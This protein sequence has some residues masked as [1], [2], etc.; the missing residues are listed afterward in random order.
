MTTQPPTNRPTTPL[1]PN[2]QVASRD[3]PFYFHTSDE[4]LLSVF[5][6]VYAAGVTPK[7][8]VLPEM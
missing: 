4:K 3:R 6:A 2:H 5:K 7:P 8:V 1:P